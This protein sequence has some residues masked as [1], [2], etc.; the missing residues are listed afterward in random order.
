MASVSDLIAQLNTIEDKEQPIIF[1]YWLA[2]DFEFYDG[3]GTPTQEQFDIVAD[4]L[5]PDHLW[6]DA[7]V[8]VLDALNDLLEDEDEDEDGEEEE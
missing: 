5:H 6:E 2:E 3:T 4:D 1:Q 8:S 7:R